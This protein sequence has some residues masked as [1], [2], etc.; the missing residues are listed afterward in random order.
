MDAMVGDAPLILSDELLEELASRW[1]GQGM[2]IASAL[3]PG[4]SDDEMDEL[5]RPIG[6]TLPCEAR[7]WWR[8]HDGAFGPDEERGNTDLGPGRGFLPLADAVRSTVTLR[9]IMRDVDGELD[10]DW[11]HSWLRLTGGETTVI[12]CG[13]A[14]DEPVPA[15][16][17]RFEEPETGEIGVPSIGTLVR[18][19]IDAFDRGQW[20]YDR[21]SGT[22]VGDY[23]KVD[24]AV[25]HLHLT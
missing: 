1:R 7:T 20:A 2:P 23:R 19:Y 9:D 3:R 14:F 13:V 22:W 21:T 18:L 15:R 8:W 25:Q 17:Y 11:R 5:T 24:P 6:I 16:H 10:P 12:D 4:L